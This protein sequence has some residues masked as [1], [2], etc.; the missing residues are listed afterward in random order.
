MESERQ[1]RIE[2]IQGRGRGVVSSRALL[3]GEILVRDSPILLYSAFP[4]HHSSP[5][6]YC[7]HCFRKLQSLSSSSSCCSHHHF[8]NP[9]CLSSSSHSPWVCHAL[10]RLRHSPIP[11]LDTQLQARFLVSA[12]NL[13]LLSPSK[14]QALLSLEGRGGDQDFPAAH[15]LHSL[16]SPIPGF[17]FSVELCLSLISKDKLNAFGLME[18][19]DVNADRSVR[20]YG[21]YPMASMFNHDCLPNAC[22]FDYVDTDPGQ[23]NT[24]IVIRMIHDVPQGREICLSYFPVN[25][26]YANR[27]KRLLE[28]YGF[29]CDCDRCK[30][31]ANWSDDE[32]VEGEEE[33]AAMEEDTEETM[34]EEEE[35][36][37]DTNFPHAYFFVRYMCKREN[38]WGTLAP[39]QPSQPN[40]ASNLMECNVCGNIKC[41]EDDDCVDADASMDK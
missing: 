33:E 36:E 23:N 9:N 24:D 28:D 3:G 31:E 25:E 1:V 21:I 34:E 22:R 13:A 14:F 40:Q 39:L 16:I 5:P 41:D 4:L 30:V 12:C 27:Q 18:P 26:N 29:S 10:T 37:E 15:F 11:S 35:E 2:K 6:F 19:F 8:C 17:P 32:V 38:C 20:A 7:D